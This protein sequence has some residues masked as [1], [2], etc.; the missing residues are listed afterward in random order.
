MSA[1]LARWRAR[2][3]PVHPIGVDFAGESL[4]LLQIAPSA[5]GPLVRAAVSL[6]YPLPRAE[7]L[8]DARALK[9]FVRSALASAPFAGLDA[10]AALAPG[11]GIR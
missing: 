7:L 2:A 1:Q 6:A 5:N 4:N 9:Q 8:A 3:V 11:D 10:V